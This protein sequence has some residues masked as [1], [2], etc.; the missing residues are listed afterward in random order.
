M[1][2]VNFRP[3]NDAD[4]PT[5]YAL[6]ESC[7]QPPFRFSRAYLRRLVRGA[8]A[9]TWI[10]EQEGQLRGFAIAEWATEGA[11]KAAYIQTIEVDPHWRERGVGA[12][13]LKRVEE[14]ACAAGAR[15][16]WLHVDAE[17]QAA[18]HLYESAGYARRGDEENY[19]PQGRAALIY[20]KE[21][22]C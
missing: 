8:R 13:L 19:Y 2:Y 10:A 16:I 17:N 14:S 4:F 5:L 9:A 3:Y 18:I 11:E 20:A 12:E 15:S 7:F 1:V 22:E 21:L 6:E